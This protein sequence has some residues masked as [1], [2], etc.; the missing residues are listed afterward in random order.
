MSQPEPR[1]RSFVR[2]WLPLVIVGGAAGGAAAAR[3]WP[4]PDMDPAFRN[5]IPTV[6][7]LAASILLAIWLLFDSPLRWKQRL[8]AFAA[9][10]LAVV[11]FFLSIREVEFTG[12]MRP[13]LHFRWS[14]TELERLAAAPAA[15]PLPPI[16][17]A[18]A[19]TAFPGYRGRR[20]DGTVP[21]TRLA[22]DWSMQPP[23]LLWKRPIG[24]GYA[25]FALVGNV[26][27]TIEQRAD[28]EAIVAYDQS[29]G[30]ER[31]I[32]E[33]PAAFREPMGGPGPR[34]TPTIADGT[35]FA[36]GATGTL[37][38]LDAATGTTIWATAILGEQPESLNLQWGMAGSPLVYDNFVVV[39]PGAGP[40]RGVVAYDRASGKEAWSAGDHKAGYSSPMLV[41]LAGTRQVLLFD[42]MGVAA[43]EPQGKGELWRFPW[44]TEQDIN[45]AQPIV[46]DN[47]RVFISSGYGAGCAMLSVRHDNGRWSVEPLWRNRWMKCKFASPVV[48]G[49]HLYGLDEGVLVC[50]DETS[51]ERQWK[52]GRY[53]HGQ[54]LLVGAH[55]LI[56]SEE[57]ELALVRCNPRQFEETGRI[58]ALAGKTWNNP[59]LAGDRLFVRNHTEA[60]CFRLALLQP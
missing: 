53:G 38:S 19:P 17:V 9:I 28:R 24:G 56:L 37:V 25:A 43:Y 36:L 22:E 31:W 13:I 7:F 41:E 1:K 20:R 26:A 21:A 44:R 45:V 60:A 39:N 57:G 12:D 4:N 30:T 27:I 23:Q 58:R 32:Y 42:G 52:A 50:L 14:P 55:L 49:G 5:F 11:G 2:R 33:Y 48:Y 3:F 47:D 10:S 54:L 16:D 51:G 46:C 35:V 40:G 15:T 18:D 29:T 34:A 6:L 59:A 8:F